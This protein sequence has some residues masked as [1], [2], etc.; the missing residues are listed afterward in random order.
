MAD[1]PSDV[2]KIGDH[3][4]VFF[5]ELWCLADSPRTYTSNDSGDCNHRHSSPAS[6]LVVISASVNP[7]RVHATE[8]AVFPPVPSKC[9][10]ISSKVF[11]FVSGKNTVAVMK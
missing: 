6:G 8:G 9:A 4:T 7:S 2:G 11:P 3:N 10:S 1:I 5:R